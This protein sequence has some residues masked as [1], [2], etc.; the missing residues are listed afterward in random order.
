[1]SWGIYK[2]FLYVDDTMKYEKGLC[3]VIVNSVKIG[4]KVWMIM[5]LW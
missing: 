5:Y 1:M 2:V 3:S 4:E